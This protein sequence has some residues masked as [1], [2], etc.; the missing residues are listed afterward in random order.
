MMLRKLTPNLMVEDV[1]R[2]IKF[3][4]EVLG[5]E[6]AQTVPETGQFEWVSIRCGNVQMMFQARASLTE[7]IPAL[8]DSKIGGSL[9]FCVCGEGL[10]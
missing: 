8:R 9:T 4:K 3:Y 1:N 5:F 7:E 10:I 6:L 2:T